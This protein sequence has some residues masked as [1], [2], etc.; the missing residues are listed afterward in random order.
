MKKK[1]QR[2]KRKKKTKKNEV[3]K[4]KNIQRNSGWGGRKRSLRSL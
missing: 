3:E 4:E 1:Y 2:K